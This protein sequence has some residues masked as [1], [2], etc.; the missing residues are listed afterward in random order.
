[1]RK[2]L[3]L[4]VVSLGLCAGAAQAQGLPGGY[5]PRNQPAVSPYL[6]LLRP[7]TPTYLNYYGLVKPQLQF[8]NAIQQLQ[9]QQA[10]TS[11]QQTTFQQYLTYPETGH[12]TSFMSHTRYFNTTGGGGIGTMGGG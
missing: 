1:M 11:A 4:T 9:S 2:T 12:A 7:D 5:N 8:G 10:Y 3:L 6:N